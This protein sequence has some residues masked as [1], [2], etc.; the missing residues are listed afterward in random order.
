ME[1]RWR[2]QDG[3]RDSRGIQGKAHA[4]KSERRVMVERGSRL[5][6]VRNTKS[7]T[8]LAFEFHK[9]SHSGSE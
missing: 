6:E 2:G 1:K 7:S 5:G 4:K 3:R 8:L 9:K